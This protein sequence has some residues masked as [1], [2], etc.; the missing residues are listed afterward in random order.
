[1]SAIETTVPLTDFAFVL[2]RYDRNLQEHSIAVPCYTG[3]YDSRWIELDRV[4]AHTLF[5][6]TPEERDFAVRRGWVDETDRW[7]EAQAR[8]K[9]VPAV[10]K[11]LASLAS[12]SVASAVAKTA[13]VPTAEVVLILADLEAAGK[14]FKRGTGQVV[15][16]SLPAPLPAAS[17]EGVPAGA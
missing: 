5:V 10:E 7:Q 9:Y 12:P 4:T 13:G 11:A 14:A 8:A 2:R 15:L 3:T 1:M 6:Q 17:V 16:W